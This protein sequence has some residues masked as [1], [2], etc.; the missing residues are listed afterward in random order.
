MH[1]WIE[2][3]DLDSDDDFRLTLVSLQSDQA[4]RPMGPGGKLGRKIVK[5]YAE[6]QDKW[7]ADFS[8]ALSR[9]LEL[10]CDPET[11]VEV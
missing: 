5:E 3:E 4:Y 10:G 6:D 8:K 9:F 7:F 2:P 1:L 11:L